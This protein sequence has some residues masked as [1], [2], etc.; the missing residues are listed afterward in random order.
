MLQIGSELW[1][2][3]V[4]ASRNVP[5]EALSSLQALSDRVPAVRRR[6]VVFLGEHKQLRETVEAL[7]LHRFLDERPA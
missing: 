4:K 3:E 1:G 2:I 5:A 7:P 6:T